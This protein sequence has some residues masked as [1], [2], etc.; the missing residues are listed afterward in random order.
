LRPA[1]GEDNFFFEEEEES[2]ESPS[3]TEHH[4]EIYFLS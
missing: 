2:F 1:L 3:E 4:T